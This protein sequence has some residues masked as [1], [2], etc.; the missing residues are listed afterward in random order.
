ML[1]V[2]KSVVTRML[3]GERQIKASEIAAIAEYFGEWPPIGFSEGAAPFE[4][5]KEAPAL[6]PIYRVAPSGD[7][8]WTLHRHAEPI[9]WRARAPHFE[10][11]ANV[12]GFYAPDD[13]MAPRFKPG[14][15]VWVDPH[16]PARPGDDALF[17]HKSA[18]RAPEPV[19]LGE[20]EEANEEGFKVI[21]HKDS[22]THQLSTRRWSAMHVFPRY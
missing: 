16:R 17:V 13:S 6:A 22:R 10:R 9:D 12:F 18:P 20:L 1:G 14:E 21:Q 5:P 15:I 4:G 11:A 19:I 7:G 8:K 2:D 3:G